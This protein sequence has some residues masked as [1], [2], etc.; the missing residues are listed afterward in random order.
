MIAN[1]TCLHPKTR[2][3]LDQQ[4]KNLPLLVTTLSKRQHLHFHQ[5]PIYLKE[6]EDTSTNFGR[7]TF[8]F[9]FCDT[10]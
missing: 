5:I 6:Q 1:Y 7:H 9:G 3:I 2:Q 4:L 10:L 8:I